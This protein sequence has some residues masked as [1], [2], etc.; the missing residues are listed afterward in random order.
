MQ[1]MKRETNRSC[2]AD[3]IA[4]SDRVHYSSSIMSSISSQALTMRLS[5]CAVQMVTVLCI[6]IHG[7]TAECAAMDARRVGDWVAEFYER[8]DVTAAAHGV[9]TVEVR[10]DCCICVAGVEGAVPSPLFIDAA[11]DTAHDQTTRM[12]NFAAAL[13]ADLASITYTV[14]GEDGVVKTT[15]ARMGVATGE[16]A[17]LISDDGARGFVSVMGETMAMATRMESLAESGAVL[18]HSSA[19]ERWATE[20]AGRAPPPPTVCVDIKGRGLQRAAV[21]DCAAAA[22]RPAAA[23]TTPADAWP[24]PPGRAATGRGRRRSLSC[25]R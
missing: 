17:F 14:N 20:K 2:G 6:D 25:P 23:P 15:A 11:A 5:T 8:V 19:A 18:L 3:D 10:G 9:S 13:H 24:C 16:A 1:T 12:L 4:V 22:F 7:F 21:F